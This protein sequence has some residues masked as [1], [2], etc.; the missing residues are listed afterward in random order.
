MSFIDSYLKNPLPVMSD[1]HKKSIQKLEDKLTAFVEKSKGPLSF[2]DCLTKFGPQIA[3]LV[4]RVSAGIKGKNVLSF[5]GIVGLF[6]FVTTISIEV[7]QIVEIMAGCVTDDTMTKE[8]KHAAKVA[9]GKQ[10]VYFVWKTIDPM[11]N[12]LNWVPFKKT[13]EKQL[14]FWLAGMGLEAT[15]DLMAANA[16]QGV[17]TM[18]ANFTI[19]KAI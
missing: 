19:M 15:V 9:F 6:K 4:E 18:E 7:Y 11:K 13:I 3:D 10:L 8:Q 5:S 16:P 14:I 12:T 1:K 17:T 2:E